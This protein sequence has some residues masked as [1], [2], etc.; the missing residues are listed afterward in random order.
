MLNSISPGE[1]YK[2]TDCWAL[3][4]MVP[5]QWFWAKAREWA[6]CKAS[7]SDADLW[8]LLGLMEKAQLRS[9]RLWSQAKHANVWVPRPARGGMLLRVLQL[10]LKIK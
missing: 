1:H 9:D 10:K 6:F 5:A 7:P 2:Y 8:E 4:L 3:F